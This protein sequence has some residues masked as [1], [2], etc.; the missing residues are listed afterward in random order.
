MIQ[1]PTCALTSPLILSVLLMCSV[2]S[3]ERTPEHTPGPDGVWP[4]NT[5]VGDV[6][7]TET[8]GHAP[9]PDTDERLRI[10]THIA[11]IEQQLRR[12]DTT[13]LSVEQRRRRA[14]ALDFLWAYGLKGDYPVNDDHSDWRRPTFMDRRGRLCAVG[15]MIG[16]DASARLTEHHKYDYLRDMPHGPV[17]QWALHNGF[18]QAE[19]ASIQP[20][21]D[22]P[23]VPVTYLCEEGDTH[24]DVFAADT[25]ARLREQVR[26]AI[27]TTQD[28]ACLAR[29]KHITHIDFD[30]THQ[31]YATRLRRDNKRV[32]MCLKEMLQRTALPTFCGAERLALRLTLDPHTVTE[33]APPQRHIDMG[34]TPSVVSA[35]TLF[36]NKP[37]RGRVT[38]QHDQ[39]FTK[40]KS[41]ETSGSASSQ[42]YTTATYDAQGNVIHRSLFEF[43]HNQTEA[44]RVFEMGA[45]YDGFRLHQTHYQSQHPWQLYD[46]VCT[47]TYPD[48]TAELWSER[49][50]RVQM[51]C[52]IACGPSNSLYEI[53]AFVVTSRREVTF[54]GQTQLHH[55][56]HK[57]TWTTDDVADYWTSAITQGE[58][59]DHFEI[60]NGI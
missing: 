4:I 29:H 46:E 52:C 60:C 6:S 20:G 28:A 45:K 54:E 16:R 43:E 40:T 21:Y 19:L 10:E 24:P 57:G 37:L 5:V 12:A 42:A 51:T 30:L 58:T 47:Y 25:R 11:Y 56:T 26:E 9:A 38:G 1:Y 14:R 59:P 49:R 18:T 15:A 13:D 44:T 53:P 32:P 22:P 50:C 33:T 27:P 48:A 2:A 17:D 8:F 35:Y 23:D 55:R 7:F 31:G 3:A 34:I 39:R 41:L 36:T